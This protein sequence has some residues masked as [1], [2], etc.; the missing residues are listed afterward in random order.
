MIHLVDAPRVPPEGHVRL[1]GLA[2]MNITKTLETLRDPAFR[3]EVRASLATWGDDADPAAID[4]TVT[5]IDD[6]RA[7]LADLLE[8]VGD[9]DDAGM[10]CAIK[11]LEF[12]AH[13]ISINTRVN[14]TAARGES[15]EQALA[16][17]G[18]ALSAMVEQLERFLPDRHVDAYHAFLAA[19][20]SSQA[21]R[22]LDEVWNDAVKPRP[23]FPPARKA[24]GAKSARN[25]T[26]Q[27]QRRLAA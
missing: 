3:T 15:V 25:R 13:W 7:D 10:V 17:R 2:T 18:A 23:A 11:L 6:I 21:T 16:F 27:Q 14:Y 12:K 26:K 5:W 4:A 20:L 24:K 19:P 9:P 1:T 8:L 22:V